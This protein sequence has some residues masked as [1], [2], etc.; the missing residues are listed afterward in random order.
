[1]LDFAACC[2]MVSLPTSRADIGLSHL[3]LVGQVLPGP[4]LVSQNLYGRG[5]K[6]PPS[7][8]ASHEKACDKSDLSNP[9]FVCQPALLG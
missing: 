3:S 4:L 2:L 9:S 6:A 8:S 7:H 1:M 5:R